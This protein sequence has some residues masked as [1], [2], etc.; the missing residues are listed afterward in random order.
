MLNESNKLISTVWKSWR[1]IGICSYKYSKSYSKGIQSLKKKRI[2]IMANHGFP[3][4]VHEELFRRTIECLQTKGYIKINTQKKLDRMYENAQNFRLL[5]LLTQY[6]YADYL[7][8][9]QNI[10]YLCIYIYYVDICFIVG[11]SKK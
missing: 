1:K 8:A 4:S 7:T 5:N 10:Q 2:I 11:L 6:K 3:F 9:Y